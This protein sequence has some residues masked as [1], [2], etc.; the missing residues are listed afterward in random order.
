MAPLFDLIVRHVPAPKV[1]PGGPFQLR[2]DIGG[3]SV[4]GPSTN[5]RIAS[6]VIKQNTTIKAL[7]RE[8]DKLEETRITKLLSLRSRPCAR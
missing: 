6:G 7:S 8:G 4:F 1:D 2:H 5:G 3:R